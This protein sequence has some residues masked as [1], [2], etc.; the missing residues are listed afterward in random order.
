LEGT[1]PWHVEGEG[2][3]SLLF[4]DIDVPF[5]HTW[6][7]NADTVLPEIP[8][9]PILQ[10]EFEKRENWLALPPAGTQLSV[11]LRKIEE[12]DELV[13]HPLGQLRVSQ[14][15]VP[16]DLVIQKV[17][18]QNIS[19]I[20]KAVLRVGTGLAQKAEV[21]EPFATA[22]FKA[23]LDAAAKLSLPAYE[24]Q[25]AGVDLSVSGNDTRTS[26]SVKRIV[27]HEL[28]TIDNNYKEHLKQFFNAGK[29]WFLQLLS[30]NA[31]ARSVLSQA[32]QT[33]RDPFVDKVAAVDPGFVIAN[34]RDNTAF[35][36][37]AT[38]TSVAQ[39]QDALAATVQGDSAIRG[40]LHVIPAAEVRRAA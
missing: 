40:T 18:N 39:A 2:S 17:G 26:H 9:L 3:I 38:F 28:I 30:S 34:T 8:A 29:L 4:W 27:L 6:G 12:T 36:G 32:N 1:S 16:L 19:D 13:L 31:T 14:R 20:E 37:T 25:M 21:R 7:E 33:A 35:G 5:S 11:S 15:A 24:K 10:A 22:Q 23:G